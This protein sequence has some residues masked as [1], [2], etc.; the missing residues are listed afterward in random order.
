MI[1][2]Y[3]FYSVRRRSCAKN[4]STIHGHASLIYITTNSQIT[5]E[6]PVTNT[7]PNFLSFGFVAAAISCIM[8]ESN[9]VDA[10]SVTQLL[11]EHY[12]CDNTCL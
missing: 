1:C 11:T 6:K 2:I 3:M 9:A 7:Q 10:D 5:S 4:R 8:S 12:R